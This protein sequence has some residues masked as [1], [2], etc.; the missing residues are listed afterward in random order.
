MGADGGATGVDD[1]IAARG[2]TNIGA[3]ILGL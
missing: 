3:W 2:F 1:E